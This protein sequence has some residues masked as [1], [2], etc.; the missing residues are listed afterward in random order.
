MSPAD[1]IRR[2]GSPETRRSHCLKHNLSG[3]TESLR[4]EKT[5][6]ISTS[7]H[8]PNTPMPDKLCPQVP[9]PDGV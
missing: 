4:L 3:F 8:H 1:A 7:N 6:K 5:S 2:S 9:H